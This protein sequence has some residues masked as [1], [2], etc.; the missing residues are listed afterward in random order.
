MDT[1]GLILSLALKTGVLQSKEIA[2]KLHISRQYAQR[3]LKEFVQKGLL[4]KLGSTRAASYVL[5]KFADQVKWKY[6]KRFQSQKLEEHNVLEDIEDRSQFSQSFSENLRSI[7]EYAFSEM[8]NNAIEHSRS[9]NIHVQVEKRGENLIFFV[10]D[11]GIGVFRNVMQKRKL[12]TELDAIQ[13]LL[14]G[15]TTT[16]P[17]AHSGEGIFFTSKVA[18]VFSLESFGKKLIINNLAKDIFIEEVKPSKKGTK[19][20]FQIACDTEKHLNDIFQEYQTDP[21]EHAFDKTEIQIKLYTLGTVHVSRSQARRV[22]SGLEKF[23]S[24]VLDFDK[25]PTI[26]QA[27][28]DEI[29][30]VFKN[31]HPGIQITPINMN[32]TIRFW[33]ERVGK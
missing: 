2:E 29:F 4:V 17:Q 9:E 11:F 14:K 31:K 33:V 7:F 8:L 28:A 16:Q 32:E 6:D 20:Y 25:V 18:D 21:T 13:D 19:V 23:K 26:G 30:R 5:P 10:N 1:K 24:V 3:I 12:K 27:F 15:K 22:L